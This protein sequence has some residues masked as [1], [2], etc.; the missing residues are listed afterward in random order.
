MWAIFDLDGTLADVS[1]RIQYIQAGD[2]DT[3]HSHC[4]DDLPYENVIALFHAV[5]VQMRTVILTG[6]SEKYREH[7][8]RWLRRFDVY[9]D[10]LLMRGE[11]NREPDVA[12]KLGMLEDFFFGREGENPEYSAKDDVLENVSICFDDRDQVVQG[13]RDYG[14]TV[15]QVREG[16]Y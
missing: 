4:E 2:W 1:H 15:C 16:D 13:F 3:F 6:R 11:F 5:N 10:E 9:P 8:E 14:L 7:T 12:M